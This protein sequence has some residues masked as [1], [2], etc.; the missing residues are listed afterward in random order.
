[1]KRIKKNIIFLFLIL[2]SISFSVKPVKAEIT[3]FEVDEKVEEYNSVQKEITSLK[4][5]D[6]TNSSSQKCYTLTL[7]KNKLLT[8]LFEIN[9]MDISCD[10]S[11]V[12]VI[13]KDNKDKCTNE[14]STKFIEIAKS[15]YKYFYVLGIFLFIIFG[16]LDWFKTI[17]SADPKKVPENRRNFFKRLTAL[18]LLFFLPYLVNLIFSVLPYH[19]G[20][21]SDRYIC[22]VASYSLSSTQKESTTP[23]KGNSSKK[24]ETKTPTTTPTPTVPTPTTLPTKTETRTV[25]QVQA[26]IVKQA[27]AVKKYTKKKK[28]T[29][30]C[31]KRVNSKGKVI[32]PSCSTK[33]VENLLGNSQKYGKYKGGYSCASL[34]SIVL[35]KAGI[36]EASDINGHNV[37]SAWATA[38][39]LRDKGWTVITDKKKLKPGDFCFYKG[40]TASGKNKKAAMVVGGIKYDPGPGHVDIYAGNG[41]VYNTGSTGLQRV[42]TSG[43]SS[44][45][46]YFAL[47]YNGK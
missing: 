43:F 45:R 41:K 26:E 33:K 29:F 36:Y 47:R 7:R 32:N 16:S 8:E 38:K 15:V 3:C 31:A 10:K 46:F 21:Y 28:K 39:Y 23:T 35:Y 24:T 11:E 5:S 27:K 19:Y 34:A 6:E 12:E 13:V 14:V 20:L 44:S 25:K 9:D 42:I 4:C 1:M 2:L 40:A 18:L 30:W 22:S 17:A 37:N